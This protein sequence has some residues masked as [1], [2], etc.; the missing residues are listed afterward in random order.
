MRLRLYSVLAMLL[1][2]GGCGAHKRVV[3]P[4]SKVHPVPHRAPALDN[5]IKKH[6]LHAVNRM[7]AKSRQC[8]NK[9]YRAAKPLRWNDRLYHAAY[10]HSKDM[11]QCSYFSHSGSGTKSDWTAKAQKL[12]RCSSFAN[13]IENNGYL[14]HR[15]IS[16]NIAYG[17]ASVEQVM[18]QW[19]NSEGHCRNI[20][21]P[22]YSDFGMAQVRSENGTYY[23]TQNFGIHQ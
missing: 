12:G 4:V 13:R 1:I 20:M 17:A 2:L 22:N 18:K 21:N 19:I 6:Y 23:W 11:A 9:I 15:G 5:A 16:E 10:E 7:R 8:G 3:Y 14:R